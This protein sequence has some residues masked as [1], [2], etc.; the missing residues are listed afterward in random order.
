MIFTVVKDVACGRLNE[1]QVLSFG[2]ASTASMLFHTQLSCLLRHH[3][4]EL[5]LLFLLL[6]F[7]FFFF[8]FLV[9]YHLIFLLFTT[10]NDV[11]EGCRMT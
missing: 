9:T 11:T 2:S 8:F 5:L 10:F 7:F 1:S 4:L 3:N 6:C